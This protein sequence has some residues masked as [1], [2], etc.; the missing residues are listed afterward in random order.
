LRKQE[1]LLTGPGLSRRPS[2][3]SSSCLLCVQFIASLHS[4]YVQLYLRQT[5]TEFNIIYSNTQDT[6]AFQPN[7]FVT[8]THGLL[9]I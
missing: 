4:K 8:E 6:T 1:G 3:S 5:T 2:L 9:A 7:V